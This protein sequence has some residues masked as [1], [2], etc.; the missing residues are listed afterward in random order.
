MNGKPIQ[1]SDITALDLCAL[2]T[3]NIATLAATPSWNGL[4][5]LVRAVSRIRG[6]GDFFHYHLLASGKIDIVIESDVNILDIAALAVI[7]REAGG[8]FTDLKGGELNLDTTSVLA[9]ST[10]DLYQLAAEHLNYQ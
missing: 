1:V 7:V 6:Y 9:A 10:Q 4:S 5:E 3:G 2:S 8:V